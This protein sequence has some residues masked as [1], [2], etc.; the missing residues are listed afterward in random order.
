[1]GKT[2]LASIFL[3]LCSPLPLQAQES[4]KTFDLLIRGGLVVD[5]SG[6][7]GRKADLGIREGRI[8]AIGD[9]SSANSKRSIDAS[10]LVV[11]PGFIDAHAHADRSARQRPEAEN[12]LLMG[13]TSVVTGNC[14][15]SEI[16]L[17]E[18]FR[19]LD[20]QGISI[21]YASLYGHGSLRRRVMGT[22]E[23]DPSAEELEEMKALLRQAMQDGAVGMSTG[24]IYVP[25]TYAKTE[26]LI[27]LSRI[28][29]EFDGVYA[30]H[31]RDEADQVLVAIDEALRIGEEAAVPVHLSH[32]KASG[33]P[34][35]GRGEEIVAMLASARKS[36][37]RVTGDQY[38]YTASSTSLD[39]L[40]PS[41]S[42][43]IGRKAFAEKLA[44]DEAFRAEMNTA[45]HRTIEAQGF[46]DLSYCQIA[47]A[48]GNKAMNGL[49]LEQAAQQF[50]NQAGPDEQARAAIRLMIEAKGSR[51][52]MVYHK[53]SEEDVAS[54]MQQAFV[55][56]AADAGII[57]YKTE[58]KPHPRGAGNNVRV[59]G[60][61]V[62]EMK[63]IPLELAIQ[64]MTSLPASSFQLEDRGE[65]R[66]GAFADICIFDPETVADRATYE[67]PLARPQGMRF[68][69]VNGAVV[70]EDGKHQ[71][72]RPGM[73]LRRTS[74]R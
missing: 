73:V 64:K 30:S 53:M 56:V 19:I 55:A 26:E 28:I 51:V 46:G 38:A 65:L 12:Y 72:I 29:A 44:S 15:S 57:D 66:K 2:L 52:S 40:F 47:S 54:I 3:L 9:L 14:G 74:G 20:E 59:L 69:I 16:D 68:V 22:A 13:V 62:R 71:G 39:V 61:Y 23:R 17:G 49:N 42:L 35:W 60:R 48:P 5:G 37:R 41:S 34:N 18:H 36:G 31:M 8:A 50:F 7:P 45:L 10:G 11:A 21:N 25:G 58:S 67:D 70:I 63:V 6:E 1:M 43:A 4:S 24:L 33:K 27:E 32:L